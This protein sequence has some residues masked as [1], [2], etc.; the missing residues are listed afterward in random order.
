MRTLAILGATG[1]I[2]AQA[3]DLIRRHPDSFQAT[4]LTA[5]SR[6]EAL[7]QAV[8]A[9]R[10]VAAG[11]VTKPE[12]IPEDLRD[13]QWFFGPD[14]SERALECARP[15]DALAAVV[16]IAGLPA[17]LKAISLCKRVLLANKEALVTGGE[18]VMRAA[19]E[20]GVALLP[21]DSEHS[22]IFQCLQCG[23]PFERLILTASGGPFRTW[24]KERIERATIGE[25]LSH[26]T[27]RMGGK[28]TVDCAS[29]MNKGLEVIE[30]RWLFGASPDQIDVVVH[31]ESIVHSLVEFKDGATLAQLGVPDMREAIGYAMNYPDRLPFGGKRLRLPDIGRLTFEEPDIDRFPCLSYAREALKA[32]GAAPTILN[33]ANEAAVSAFLAGRIPFGGIPRVVDGVLQRTPLSPA[34]RVEDVYEAD[35]LARER[36]AVQIA[37]VT[38][39]T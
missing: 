23:S 38:E 37:R 25:A 2:G 1:S 24:P 17:V 19:K 29:L 30:A 36:A 33:G 32:G 18:L 12:S 21:V 16:G 4:A 20:K 9:F 34:Q 27:W 7:F 26:P 35:R 15:D 6:A 11:L 8:R 39:R 10:P 3:L 13:V 28:I 5:G 14:C 31:P 22:A